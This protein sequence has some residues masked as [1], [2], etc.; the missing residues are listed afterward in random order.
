MP[1]SI[2]ELVIAKGLLNVLLFAP[3]LLIAVIDLWVVL[4]QRGISFVGHSLLLILSM[5]LITVVGLYINLRKPSYDWT[6]EMVVV[7]QSLSVILTAVSSMVLIAVSAIVILFLNLT[8][9]YVLILIESLLLC[10]MLSQM[11]HIRYL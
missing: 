3:G 5:M 8:G 11:K 6:S 2:K 4:G 10:F 1:I 9:V 7:K